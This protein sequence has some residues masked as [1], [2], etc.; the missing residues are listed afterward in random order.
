MLDISGRF[1]NR[2]QDTTYKFGYHTAPVNMLGLKKHHFVQLMS[3]PSLHANRGIFLIEALT[4]TL[5]TR[6]PLIP[7]AKVPRSFVPM[8]CRAPLCNPYTHNFAFGYE[9]DV[10]GWNGIEGDIDVPIPISKNVAYRFPFSGNFYWHPDNKTVTYGHNFNNI[11]PYFSLFEYQK[12][13]PDFPEDIFRRR[14]KRQA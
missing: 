4:T 6:Q 13:S 14:K 10:G 8:S 7:V 12:Y 2:I 1:H 9:E 5:P 11:E 3:D